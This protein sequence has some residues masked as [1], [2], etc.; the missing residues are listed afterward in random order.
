MRHRPKEIPRYRD[1][2]FYGQL[3]EIFEITLPATPELLLDQPYTFLLA[4]IRPCN[5]ENSPIPRFHRFNCHTH[6]ASAP[7]VVDLAVL[8][9]VVGRI[10][11][12]RWSYIV[13]RSTVEHPAVFAD[14]TVAVNPLV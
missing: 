4:R 10:E 2:S 14:A 3:L 11:V 1:K 6:A 13:D 12:E 9:A 5:T 8:E 7:E